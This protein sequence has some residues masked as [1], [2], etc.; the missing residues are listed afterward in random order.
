[1]SAAAE[2]KGMTD[3]RYAEMLAVVGPANQTN[4]LAIGGQLPVDDSLK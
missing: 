1:M 4:R 3:A 2:R